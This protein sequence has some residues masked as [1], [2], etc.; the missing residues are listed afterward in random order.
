MIDGPMDSVVFTVIG[1]LLVATSFAVAG[2]GFSH[3]L[4]RFL[5]ARRKARKAA[6]EDSTV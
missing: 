6:R 4:H 2:Y 1:S 3:W 5:I